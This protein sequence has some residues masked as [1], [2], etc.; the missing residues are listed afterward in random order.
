MGQSS[1]FQFFVGT[2]TK[3][4]CQSK[5]IYRM[6]LDGE[7]FTSKTLATIQT[8]NPSFLHFDEDKKTLYAVNESGKDSKISAF[9]VEENRFA[10]LNDFDLF[11][12]DPCYVNGTSKH[13]ITAE[14]TSGTLHVFEK[15]EDGSI[16]KLIQ[17]ISYE[18]SALNRESRLHQIIFSP[19]QKFLITS[20]LGLDKISVYHYDENAD[21]Q[22]LSFAF[23]AVVPENSGPRHLTF[24][25]SGRF[26]FSIQ[27]FSGEILVFKFS[28]NSLD[29]LYS[30]PN[31]N[32]NTAGNFS[33]AH[34]E[35]STDNRFLYTS[36]R[37]GTTNDLKVYKILENLKLEHLQT[38]ETGIFPRHF[39]LSPNGNFVLVAN[40]KSNF[41]S[42]FSRDS[43]SGLLSPTLKKIPIC[44]PVN[45][46]FY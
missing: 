31:V 7:D 27:E 32:T 38:I 10:F 1:T 17:N 20:D 43:S 8:E 36:N 45:I 41:I 35:I 16:G 23:D 4:D 25:R 33:S 24:D 22:V 18:S 44:S 14:Y 30:Y 34:I 15:N 28:P 3:T 37:G 2:Y 46:L 5:G 26:I 19:D 11:G 42:I 40:E 13:L 9:K 39:S 21:Q 12:E 29:L 6:S